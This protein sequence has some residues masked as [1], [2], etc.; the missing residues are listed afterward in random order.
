MVNLPQPTVNKPAPTS[1]GVGLKPVH[2]REIL[3]TAPDIDW[4][5]IHPENFMFEGGPSHTWLH[6][7][8]QSYDLSFH[9]VAM[10]LGSVTAVDLIHLQKLSDLRDIYAPF[11]MSDHVSWSLANGDFLND[12]LPLP[13]T[14]ESLSVLAQNIDRAQTQL[15]QPILVENPSTYLQFAQQDYDEPDFLSALVNRTGCGLLLDI[16][17]AYVCARNHGFDPWHYLQRIPHTA[18]GEIHL[19]GHS[20]TDVEGTELRIDDHG[21][22][23][24]NEVWDLYGRYVLTYGPA[25]TLIEWDANIPALSVLLAEANKARELITSAVK[26]TEDC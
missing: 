13:Y 15:D 17:N 2:Y 11:I 8:R 22:A 26:V 7:I 4:F 20:V 5:E 3:E 23:V 12:L 19:A 10:S 14:D 6:Q 1:V 18:V 24:S 25:P 9:S 16:N 21:S